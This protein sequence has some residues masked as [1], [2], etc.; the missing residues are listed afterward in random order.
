MTFRAVKKVFLFPIPTSLSRLCVPVLGLSVFFLLL[1]ACG[2]VTVPIDEELALLNLPPGFERPSI[3]LD[4]ALNQARVE[5]GK[6]LFYDPALSR[7]SSIS[8][9]SCHAPERAFTDGRSLSLGVNDAQGMRNSPTLVNLAWQPYFMSEGGVPSLESQ[10]G[11][12]IQEH[13]EFDFNFVLLAERLGANQHYQ[14]MSRSA[15]GRDIDPFVISR[16]IAAFERILIS[17]RSDFDR[18][19]N[20][21]EQALS[22]E[23]IRGMD[24]FFSERTQ[25]SSCHGGTFLTTYEFHNNGLYLDYADPGRARLTALEEDRALF[26]V[27]TLRNIAETAPYMHD[28]S[29]AT[30]DEVLQH[31]RGGGEA[32]P[33]KSP[34]IQGLD[35]SDA[36]LADLKAFLLALSDPDFLSN[37]A[38]RP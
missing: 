24:L 21:D 5:L 32:H 28:G 20:G 3:P 2:K 36:E 22:A 16:A 29:M 12:P 19:Q 30:L 34:L 18:Y 9:A 27:P 37:P 38:F 15:Y 26:K 11:V 33:N 13:A 1:S 4:N 25:C 31:Y 14:Q 10:V 8:C 35:L 7:D 23:E 17:G 6:R